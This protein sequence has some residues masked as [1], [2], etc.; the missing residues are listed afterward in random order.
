MRDLDGTGVSRPTCMRSTLRW[1]SLRIDRAYLPSTLVRECGNDMTIFCKA[2]RVRNA[3]GLAPRQPTEERARRRCTKGQ[4]LR[5]GAELA[6]DAFPPRADGWHPGAML[7]YAVEPAGTGRPGEGRPA[8]PVHGLLRLQATAGN[9]AVSRMLAVQRCGGEV[10]PGCPCAEEEA[11]VRQYGASV[12]QRHS[13]QRFTDG[14]AEAPR[15]ELPPGSPYAGLHPDLLAMLG[16]TLVAKIFG[17]WVNV[18]PTN[19]GAALDALGASDLNTLVQLHTRLAAAG[20]WGN[21]QTIKKV[22]ST[23]SLGVDY[24]GPDMS[25]AVDGRADFCKDT[26]IGESMHE[27][28]SCWRQMVAPGTPGLHVCKPGSVHIDPHQTVETSRGTGWALGGRWGVQLVDRCKYAFAAWFDHMADV[29]G[30][31]PVNVFTRVGQDRDKIAKLRRE[32]TGDAVH[33]A[34]LDALGARLDA[35]TLVLRRWATTGMEGA[36]APAAEVA[37]VQAELTAV[38]EGLATVAEE[39]QKPPPT[40]WR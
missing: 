14:T 25:A 1:A 40:R 24:N 8:I 32:L 33:I 6:E 30:G 22:W 23:S 37:S 36:D 5:E 16:R 3:S 39:T 21:I 9:R 20:L 27:G 7:R 31:R 13:V 12:A 28:Q 10:H 26:A 4:P 11:P 17:H 38:E 18:K 15:A 35:L 34:A 2:W 19:L 29:A